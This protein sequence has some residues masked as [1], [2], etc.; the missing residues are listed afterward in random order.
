MIGLAPYRGT[1]DLFPPEK[2]V[3]DHVFGKMRE[4]ALSFGY[5]AYDGP[6]LETM[7]LY[8]VKSGGE[9]AEEQAY[10]F[11]DRGGR[12]VAIRPE[13]TPTLA[14]MVA[15][16]HKGIPKPI[17]W[18][19]IP[20]LMRYERPQRGRLREHWQ[21]NCDVFG[22]PPLLG[23]AEVAQLAAALLSG[24]G[25]TEAH[26]RILLNDR[27]LVSGVLDRVAGPD[28]A[29]RRRALGVIDKAKKIPPDALRGMLGD[30]GL[31]AERTRDL[32]RYLALE[33]LDGAGEF[34][35][36]MGL[37]D[38]VAPLRGL[39]GVL[40]RLGLDRCV[41]FDP[42]VVRGIDYYTGVV[43]EIFDRHPDNNRA[44]CG[45]GTYDDLLRVF[46][47]PA[48]PGT[49]FGLGDVTLVDFLR[50]HGLLGDFA[51]P[52]ADLFL[53]AD[54]G[55]AGPDAAASAAS[56]MALAGRLRARGLRVV[57]ALS[58]MRAS[59]AFGAAE[60][61]GARFV[62]LLGD[63]G[64]LAVKDAGSGDRRRFPPGSDAAAA[65]VAADV[66][67]FVSGAADGGAGP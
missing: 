65:D 62:G 17:R 53:C 3:Q 47:G 23:E 37:S 5:E 28:P 4:T 34:L 56:A 1:R 2:R 30:L 16:V 50:S 57:A 25:A 49:G 33:S 6:L 12:E 22:A 10:S 24:L 63:D 29:L 52:G 27:R 61:R 59:K 13:M 40:G 19:S 39:F 46:G 45:G 48:L 55:G 26:F 9:L 15:S 31:D 66:A 14:R 38:L 42:A 54:A 21:L 7:E 18:F 64:S 11:T 20:N 44:L 36:G 41:A 58:P 51:R 67:V 43:F 32:E 60:R 8:R 35:G